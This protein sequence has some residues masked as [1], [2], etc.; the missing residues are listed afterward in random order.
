MT[1]LPPAVVPTTTRELLAARFWSKVDKRGTDECWLWLGATNGDAGHG[2]LTVCQRR[3]YAHRVSWELGHGRPVPNG[4]FVLH[5]CDN[6][7]CVNPAHLFT[8]TQADNVA[9]MDAKGRRRSSFAKN[10]EVG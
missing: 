1:A 5:R 7:R 6:P 2:Q 8:G 9:D 4:L 3:H 10:C